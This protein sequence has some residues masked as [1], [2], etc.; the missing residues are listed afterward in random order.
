MRW[1]WNTCWG[2]W[3][4]ILVCYTRWKLDMEFPVWLAVFVSLYFIQIPYRYIVRSVVTCWAGWRGRRWQSSLGRWRSRGP[5][6]GTCS[7]PRTRTSAS[8]CC[9]RTRWRRTRSR[10]RGAGCWGSGSTCWSGA[11]WWWSTAPRSWSRQ[12]ALPSHYTCSTMAE[13]ALTCISQSS[14]RCKTIFMNI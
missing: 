7:G 1:L 14:S 12:S 2:E 4:G 13:T 11:C 3:Y 6:R 9:G 8:P 10:C 5:A